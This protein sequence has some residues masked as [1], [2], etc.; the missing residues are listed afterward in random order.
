MPQR[1]SNLTRSCCPRQGMAEPVMKVSYPDAPARV[2]P[3]LIV[4]VT[5]LTVASSGEAQQTYP[6]QPT[7]PAQT[8]TP[9]YPSTTYPTTA[10]P[11]YPSTT[12]PQSTYPTYATPAYPAAYGAPGYPG[13]V[14]PI[15]GAFI[16]TVVAVVGSGGAALLSG[17]AQFIVGGILGWFKH[18]P[19][20]PDASAPMQPAPAAGSPAGYGYPTATN[21]AAAPSVPGAYNAYPGTPTG[22]AAPAGA[23][24]AGSYP[25]GGAYPSAMNPGPTSPGVASQAPAPA[26]TYPSTGV[27]SYPTT[28]SSSP[29]AGYPTGG[30]TS[31]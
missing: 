13:E 3:S 29:S 27:P 5:S 19:H 28:A 26:A 24:A 11:G 12:Y 18:K 20:P 23:Y 9:T 22:M 1:E 7:Y 31:A 15:R 17:L 2:W 14:S 16:A 21:P 30:T 6:G 4:L 10:Y 25:A 8:T